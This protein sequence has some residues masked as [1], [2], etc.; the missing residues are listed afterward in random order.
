MHGQLADSGVSACRDCPAPTYALCSSSVLSLWQLCALVCPSLRSLFSYGSPLLPP[1]CPAPPCTSPRSCQVCDIVGLEWETTQS[2]NQGENE[3]R[4]AL[5]LHVLQSSGVG[6]APAPAAADAVALA[7][8]PADRDTAAKQLAAAPQRTPDSAATRPSSRARSRLGAEAAGGAGGSREPSPS[9]AVAAGMVTPQLARPSPVAA[10]SGRLGAGVGG[11]IRRY[12]VMLNMQRGEESDGEDEEGSEGEHEGSRGGQAAGSSSDDEPDRRQQAAAPAAA[13]AAPG[14]AGRDRRAAL[15]A[16]AASPLP[17]PP[18]QQGGSA[19]GS[20]LVQ[21]EWQL[22]GELEYVL[23]LC[24]LE[25][26]EQL[27]HHEVT[28]RRFEGARWW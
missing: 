7:P 19:L 8:Q 24:I 5:V 27:P 13:Q 17:M 10:A 2:L 26:R 14:T 3:Y 16:A 15:Q 20:S 28:V 23:R 4:P 1:R 18:A 11:S 12:A 21:R 22:L 25:G 9:K 6:A